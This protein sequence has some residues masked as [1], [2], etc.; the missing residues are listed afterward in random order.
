MHAISHSLAHRG[1]G[2]SRARPRW[3]PYSASTPAQSLRTSPQSYLNTPASVVTPSP[4]SIFNL[5]L[6]KYELRNNCISASLQ[7]V[8][9]HR[10]YSLYCNT[11]STTNIQPHLE[12]DW[13][14]NYTN[15][16]VDSDVRTTQTTPLRLYSNLCTV[17]WKDLR[18]NRT[19]TTIKQARAH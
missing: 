15:P 12:R 4:P 8:P 13:R 3:Q 16:P 7:L 2:A 1:P 17:G 18:K 11:I 9:A 5:P 6:I 14:N 10:C 19:N